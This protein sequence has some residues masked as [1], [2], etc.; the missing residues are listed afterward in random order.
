MRTIRIGVLPM[1][2]VLAVAAASGTGASST[3]A[4]GGLGARVAAFYAHNQHGQSPPVLG[5]TNATVIATRAGRVTQWRLETNFRPRPSNFERLVLLGGV[6]LPR[7]AKGTRRSSTCMVWR[8]R[9][10]KNL[11]GMEYAVGTT[12]TGTVSSEIRAQ[13]QPRC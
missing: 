13:G 3:A 12:V 7:D 10:L 4:Y 1:C 11:I 5:T 9:I 6:N 2:V 8:S